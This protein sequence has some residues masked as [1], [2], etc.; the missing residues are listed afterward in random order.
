MRPLTLPPLKIGSAMASDTPDGLTPGK[1]KRLQQC[2]EHANLQ[3]RQENFD[4]ATELFGQCVTGDPQNVL[5][6]QGFLGNLKG[7]YKNNRKGDKLASVKTLGARGMVKKSSVQ[8]DW[9]GVVK[10]GLDVLK[11]NPWDV[12]TLKAIAA[13]SKELGGD[14][15]Q[16][17]YLRMALECNMKDAEINRICARALGDRKIFDQAIACWHRVEQSHPGDEEAARAIASLTVQKTIEV[18]KWEGSDPSK[19]H[20]TADGSELT[21]EQRLQRDI[22]R[23]PNDL[24]KYVEL[25][26]LY[27]RDELFPKAEQ[28]L[29]K[30]Y[31]ISDNNADIRERWEDVQMRNLRHQLSLAEKQ[32]KKTGKEEDKLRCQQIKQELSEKDMAFCRSR[33]ERFPLNL[34]FKY[35]LAIRL[36]QVGK[37]TEAIAEYQKAQNDPKYKGNC[38]LALGQCFQRIKQYKLAVKHYEGAVQ[39]IAERDVPNKKKALYLFGKLAAHLGD[40]DAAEQH[41]TTLAQMDFAY[42]DVSALLDKIAQIR[43]NKGESRPADEQQED[44]D[45]PEEQERTPEE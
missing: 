6:V 41:L 18:G 28:T 13:A 14:D 34:A 15:A 5:Y 35:Q 30:A 31:E 3:M 11:L 12:S 7:K 2:Y 33:V 25:A 16:L 8:K 40:L 17:A 20:K 43:E 29:Q 9:K 36:Q 1:R 22:R 44:L 24:A 10:N 4:Y 21:P 27:I 37:Y 38:M 39:D 23:N 19:I 45:P 26:E 32:A 42:K